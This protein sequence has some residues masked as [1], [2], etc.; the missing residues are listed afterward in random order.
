MSDSQTVDRSSSHQDQARMLLRPVAVAVFLFTV[1]Y[2]ANDF[3]TASTPSDIGLGMFLVY[4]G[5]ALV[6]AGVV[7][8]LVLPWALRRESSGG[9]A[10]ALAILGTLLAPGFWTGFPPGLAA[11]GALLGWAGIYATKGRKLSQAAFVIGV[12]GVVFNVVSYAEVFI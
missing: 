11:G 5:I 9:L 12:L 10:L 3:A 7:F 1:S 4:A 8:A 2:P 6:T